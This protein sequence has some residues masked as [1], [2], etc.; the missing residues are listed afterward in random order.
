A[1]VAEGRVDC[2]IVFKLDR[3]S[4]SVV[5]TVNLVLEEWDD[6][7]HVKSAREPID[8]TNHAGKMF[9]YMLVSYAEWERSV[10]R[11]RTWGGRLKRAQE[12]RNPGFNA[13]YGYRVGAVPGTLEIVPE[14]AAVVRRIY[15]LY[16]T[17]AGMLGIVKTLAGEG[18]RFREGRPWNESTVRH[19]LANP[20]YTGDLVWGL[21]Q[22]NPR[23]GKRDGEKERLRAD[24]P[25]AAREGAFPAIVSRSEFERVGLM[26]NAKPG[27]NRGG[28]G[29]AVSSRFLLSGLAKCG[30]CG[31]SILGREG[32]GRGGNT[33]YWCSG[34]NSKGATFCNCGY[35]NTDRADAIAVAELR[36]LYG[37]KAKREK[38][39]EVMRATQQRRLENL[40]PQAHQVDV[41]VERLG[42][43]EVDLR[44]QYREKEITIAEFRAFKADLDGEKLALQ[45]KRTDLEQQIAEARRALVNNDQWA[46]TLDQMDEWEKLTVPQRKTLLRLLCKGITLYRWPR[47]LDAELVA[48]WVLP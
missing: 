3:L 16:L 23:F 45:R 42:E 27:P 7:C 47:G 34:R 43:Q 8:T 20:V 38:V 12:G 22:R 18:A 46:L 39:V 2:V 17:G 32:V 31:S 26:R 44:R 28:S 24:E 25:L 40:L 14:E 9:F 10:I 19:I 11:E 13:P 33:Y 6:R 21:R 35:I 48:D 36:R 37:D 1:Q 30:K 4:R 29:R 5:D 41:D 15:Q